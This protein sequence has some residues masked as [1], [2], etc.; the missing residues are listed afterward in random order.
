VSQDNRSL[1]V[2]PVV[3]D[4]SQEENCRVLHG[5]RCKEVVDCT[6]GSIAL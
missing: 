5:L 6:V 1:F 2:R 4:E 3:Q